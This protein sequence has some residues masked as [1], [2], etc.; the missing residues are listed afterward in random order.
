MKAGGI[1]DLK[2]DLAV[3][4]PVFVF[5]MLH[6]AQATGR[7]RIKRPDNAASIY[8]DRGNVRFAEIATRSVKLGEYLVKAGYLSKEQ[9]EQ[10]LSRKPARVRL[11]RVLVRENILNESALKKALEE[12]IMEVVFEVVTWNKGTF[13][14]EK[15]RKPKS[16]DI[17]INVPLDRLM[18]EGLKRFDESGGEKIP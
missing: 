8:F 13:T 16:Q 17:F 18:L 4:E 2:G 3:F 5:Q 1:V 12:Q 11:G 10:L 14:F 9:V 6:L 15:D 7:L